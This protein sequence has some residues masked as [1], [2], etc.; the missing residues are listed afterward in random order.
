MSYPLTRNEHYDFAGEA[1]GAELY[2]NLHPYPATM[3]PQL[4]IDILK[5]LNITQGRMLDPYCGSGSS[6]VAGMEVGLNDFTGYDIN[7]LAL[8]ICQ[9]R[10]TYLDIE[11]L[12]SLVQKLER[13]IER[14]RASPDTPDNLKLEDLKV[15]KFNNFDYW[16]SHRAGQELQWLKNTIVHMTKPSKESEESQALRRFLFLP[17]SVAMRQCSY[18][19]DKEFKL[20]RMS[21]DKLENFSPPVFSLFV[22]ALR[23]CFLTYKSCYAR[24]LKGITLAT[25]LGNHNNSN[26]HE[27][28]NYDVILTSPPYGDSRT[29][30][31]YGQFSLFANAWLLEQNQA[32]AIDNLSL[33]GKKSQEK[34]CADDWKGSALGEVVAAIANKDEARAAEVTAFYRDL[35]ESMALWME[36]LKVGGKAVVVVGNRTV[37]GFVLPTDQFVAE[38]MEQQH[39]HHEVSYQRKISR[40]RMPSRNSPRN[41][42]GETASTMMSEFIVVGSK[43]R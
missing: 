16:F 40:K 27:A 30:V 14:L 37:K 8:L 2:P 4:G 12:E 15:E 32:R 10:L 20:Y 29:T 34:N 31:A 33:G 28:N 9:A 3:I 26:H 24:K 43:R 11:K 21:E 25:K 41:K 22:R 5:E 1:Y 13:R 38:C 39:L 6:F 7:P 18:T 35:K 36:A 19:R 23:H 17:L 42:A